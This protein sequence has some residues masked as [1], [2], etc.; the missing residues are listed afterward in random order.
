MT[1]KKEHTLRKTTLPAISLLIDSSFGAIILH[2]PHQVAKK[3]TTTKV[4]YIL[5]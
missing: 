1:Y 4:L 5:F 3:S 2:G